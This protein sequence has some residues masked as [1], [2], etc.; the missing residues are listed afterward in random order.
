MSDVDGIDT[1]RIRAILAKIPK[2]QADG[3]WNYSGFYSTCK[4][5]LEA[6]NGDWEPLESVFVYA[7]EDDWIDKFEE[8]YEEEDG[9]ITEEED[10]EITEEEES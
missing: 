10:G 4:E 8:E 2:M 3:E 7:S 1:D 6:S 5:V 9:E